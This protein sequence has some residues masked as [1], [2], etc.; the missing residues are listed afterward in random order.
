MNGSAREPHSPE[1][2]RQWRQRRERHTYGAEGK[3]YLITILDGA[4]RFVVRSRFCADEGMLSHEN[5]LLAAIEQHGLPRAYY[6]DR[7]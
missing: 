7:R 6:V 1:R 2:R 3:S 4:T 5:V